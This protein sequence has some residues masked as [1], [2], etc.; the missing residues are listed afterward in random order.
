[1]GTLLLINPPRLTEDGTVSR[2]TPVETRR[3]DDNSPFARGYREGVDARREVIWRL[4]NSLEC[5]ALWLEN[6]RDPHEAADELRLNL[7][8][9]R[10]LR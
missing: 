6:G 9:L 5:T 7:K 4:I 3:I 1:M 8:L 10:E 2:D